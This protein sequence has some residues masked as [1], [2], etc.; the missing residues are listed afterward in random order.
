MTMWQRMKMDPL[1]HREGVLTVGDWAEIR[2][3]HRVEQLPIKAI[4]RRLRVSRN[5]VRRALARDAPPTYAR[6]PAGSIVDAVEPAI[7]SC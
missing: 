7:R 2:R 6:V 5:A 1:R 4:A 3:P